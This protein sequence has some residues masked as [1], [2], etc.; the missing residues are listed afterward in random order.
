MDLQT[1][2]VILARH[3]AADLVEPAQDVLRELRDRQ[4]NDV[5]CYYLAPDVKAIKGQKKV[6]KFPSQTFLILSEQQCN[7]FVL[8]D[9]LNDYLLIKI[10]SN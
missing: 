7:F 10:V 1:P 5:T 4:R 9:D 6:R 3:T 8:L 2:L